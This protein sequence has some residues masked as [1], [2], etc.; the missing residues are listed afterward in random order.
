MRADLLVV[1]R[2]AKRLVAV[3][4]EEREARSDRAEDEDDDGHEGVR[5]HHAA[6]ANN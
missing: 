3:G 5:L 2:D 1:D 6:V 4:G